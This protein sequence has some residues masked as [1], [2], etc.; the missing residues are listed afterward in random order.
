MWLTNQLTD[1]LLELPLSDRGILVVVGASHGPMCMHPCSPYEEYLLDLQM[2]YVWAALHF[3]NSRPMQS[4]GIIGEEIADN[5]GTRS[6]HKSWRWVILARRAASC[7]L[8]YLFPAYGAV[9]A[10]NV[11]IFFSRTYDPG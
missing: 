7:L 5:P 10:E 8:G 11:D 3:G 1:P 2:S 9:V 6:N 4:L